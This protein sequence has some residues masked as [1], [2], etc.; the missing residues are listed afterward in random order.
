MLAT[1]TDFGQ[2]TE[3]TLST[4][5]NNTIIIKVILNDSLFAELPNHATMSSLNYIM[6]SQNCL[7]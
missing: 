5:K 4:G 2:F 6:S 7:L 1:A 3:L